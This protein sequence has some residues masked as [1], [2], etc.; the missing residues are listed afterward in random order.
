MNMLTPYQLKL[1]HSEVDGENTPEASIEV[2]KL[3][4][5]Q[6]EALAFMTSLQ[7]LDA[8]FREVPD[9]APPPRVVRVIHNAMPLN[10]R[11][12]P[13]AGH[14]QGSTQTITRWIIQQW[15]GV[16][17]LM[18]ESMLTKKALIIGTTA[19]AVI[20]IVGWAVVGYSP[21]IFDAGTIGAGDSLSGVQQA[22]R[23]KG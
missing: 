14:A 11:A 9:R 5:T 3:V 19:V 15:N 10:S 2:R 17:N 12:S 13:R 18:E 23:Y 6:P 22:G 16:T 1:I 21:S 20:A 8:L 4:E 7:G